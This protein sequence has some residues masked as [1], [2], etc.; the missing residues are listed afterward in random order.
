M[1]FILGLL[2][3]YA[4][5]KSAPHSHRPYRDKKRENRELIK[6]LEDELEK[7]LSLVR[8]P[9]LLLITAHTSQLTC[10]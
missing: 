2:N 3:V 1:R 8:A 9:H 6:K 10:S 4:F 5:S 7:K